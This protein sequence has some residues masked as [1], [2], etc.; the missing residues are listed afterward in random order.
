M[1]SSDVKIHVTY[2]KE[3]WHAGAA[4][5]VTLKQIKDMAIARWT[6]PQS[7]SLNLMLCHKGLK[8]NFP[9][10]YTLDRVVGFTKTFHLEFNL[11]AAA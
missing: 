1:N 2:K 6:I 11:N 8:Y 3:V 9:D 4:G 7:E 10:Y 5:E